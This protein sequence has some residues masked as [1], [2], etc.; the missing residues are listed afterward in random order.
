MLKSLMVFVISVLLAGCAARQ[1]SI[2]LDIPEPSPADVYTRLGKQ[3]MERGQLDLALQNFRRAL[4][5]DSRSSEAHHAIAILYRQLD[6]ER[7]AGSHLENAVALRPTNASAQTDHASF[8]CGKGEY[9]KA[10]H[11][12]DIAIN[13]PLYK[14]P[15]V[16]M[17]NA[18]ICAQKAGNLDKAETY[19]RKALDKQPNFAPALLAMTRI[20]VAKGNAMSGR[21]FLQRYQ[22]VGKDTAESLALGMEIESELGDQKAFEKYRSQLLDD[23]PDSS[24]AAAISE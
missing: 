6:R 9:A 14:R 3:Y 8:L 17:T 13:T 22:S 16:A 12:F 20:S 23:F 19:L 7:L 10:E 1:Q 4:D 2:D 11:H 24:E 5:I 18:G 15:W 21:A